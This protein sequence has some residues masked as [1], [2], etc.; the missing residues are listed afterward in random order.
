MSHSLHRIAITLACLL[1]VTSALAAKKDKEPKTL[2]SLSSQSIELPPDAPL[3][4][5]DAGARD[6]YRKYLETP[7][8]DPE[9]SAEAMR[10]LGDL[11]LEDGEAA[12]LDADDARLPASAY[13]AAIARYRELLERYP[14]DPR[15]D[16]V[17][18]QL[19]RA[20]DS[21][22]DS[23]GALSS[24]DT[25]VSRYPK[26]ANL[27]EVQFRRGELLFG[28]KR[29]AEAQRAYEAVLALPNKPT[30]R[31]PARYKLGWS[32]F[33]QDRHDASVRAFLSLLDARF[34]G[35]A[36]AS[37]DGV[38]A[39]MPV[40]VRELVDDSLRATSLSFSFEQGLRSLQQAMSE[41]AKNGGAAPYEH[42][43][44]LSL[45]DQYLEQK[46]W[47]DAAGVFSGY[48]ESHP[49]DARS[50]GLQQRAIAALDQ[51]NFPD[52]A[53]AARAV[54]VEHFGPDQPYWKA[55]KAPP[56]ASTLAVLRDSTWKVSQ[57]HHALAQ[58][59][60]LSAEDRRREYA[61]AA[62]GYRRY[63][64]YFPKD[65]RIPEAQFLLGEVLYDEGD[66]AQALLAYESSAYEFPPHAHSAEAGYAALLAYEKNEAKLSGDDAKAWHRRRLDAGLRF[67]AAFPAHQQ[68][69]AAR[70]GAAEG[71][72]A[73][74]AATDA[75]NAATAVTTS[76]SAT[77]D[78]R[79]AA[80]RVLGHARVDAKD[81]AGAEK[82]YLEATRLDLAA[83]RKDPELREHLAAAIYLQGEKAR[84][85]GEVDEAAAAFLRV[86]RI[87]P[88]SPT[89]ATADYEA[90]QTYL[91]AGRAADAVPILQRFAS[92]H[93]DSPL[94]SAATARLA[95]AYIETR[96]EGSAAKAF[97]DIANDKATPRAEQQEALQQA[98]KLYASRKD[99]AGQTR[100]LTQFITRFPDNFGGV[101]E[102]RHRLLGLAV[103]RHDA[104]AAKQL[105]ER[106]IADDAAAGTQRN[107]RS[108][109]LAAQAALRLADP[110]REAFT[111]TRLT[112]PLDKSLKR[113]KAQMETALA[114]YGRAADYGVA[115]ALT[116]STFRLG[117]I[118]Q[119]LAQSLY[120]SERPKKLDAQAL[121]E[122][123]LIVQEQAF[124]FEE[125]AIELHEAN[126]RRAR[127]GLYDAW[128]RNSYTSLASLVPGRYARPPRGPSPSQT[129][130][131]LEALATQ[132]PTSAPAQFQLGQALA[133]EGRFTDADAAFARAQAADG[134][135]ARAFYDRA[136]LNELY[137]EQP[138]EAIRNYESFQALLDQSDPQVKSWIDA[139]RKRAAAV[140][141]K[142]A[143]S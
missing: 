104:T 39:S 86:G 48:V 131:A 42:L 1:T 132:N 22:G 6:H 133:A 4:G 60:S 64:A 2:E 77:P 26:A 76:A 59:K 125:K 56:D 122:Y 15:N 91:A 101:L 9:R 93:R 35:V 108:R 8:A 143:G 47:S 70:L 65:A 79:R 30:F 62:D 128:V 127:S 120:D 102:A 123:D 32:L 136:V 99:E 46:R 114:A 119:A 112:L 83:N 129:R 20:Q 12:A 115:D 134:K 21:G 55:Q 85:A 94:A 33:R 5:V 49:L 96:D 111:A 97:E 80:W 67:A 11:E 40:A 110:L 27:D 50:Q 14:D 34:E 41:R 106:Q 69:A 66:Y 52:Q 51:G 73:G 43:V 89:V 90:A 54:Y 17:L 121:A 45:A 126:A 28:H 98:A 71:L 3:T 116:E 61:S 63:R 117:E 88:D 124:P 53:I 38:V 10:R 105:A 44:Y 13:T 31:E 36:P 16:A 37:V 68:A 58:S 82:A 113:K 103:A 138:A 7:S 140:S 142:G 107:D 135:Y 95:L 74:G 78:Q 87:T 19:A 25:L 29:F 109:W 23:L 139:L 72:L 141:S 84:E 24:L 18:Y 130:A 118:Y 81:Y 57:Q 75:A 92:A 100:L 137:L